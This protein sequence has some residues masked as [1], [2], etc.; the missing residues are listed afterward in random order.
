[1]ENE[2]NTYLEQFVTENRKRTFEKILNVRTRYITVVLEDI[3][4]P[5]NA[6]AVLRTCE[7]FGIQ[8]V[9]IIENKNE[10]TVNPDVVVGSHKWLSLY[11]YNTRENNSVP[12]IQNLKSRGYRIV[13]TVPRAKSTSLEHFNLTRGKTALLFGTELQGLSD[14]IM[15]ASDEF[16]HIP[17]TG[18]TQSF[19]ISVSVAII[20]YELTKKLRNT[21]IP[22]QLSYSEK[23]ILKTEWLKNTIKN[24]DQLIQN[25]KETDAKEENR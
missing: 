3:Y 18:F 25:F 11:K 14:E 4:Q 13:S 19:N 20:L 1:M 15:D 23:Q 22:W 8:D 7:C 17:M 16:L 5:H 12:A 24:A 10:Y 9:H 6:S 21:D 2:L